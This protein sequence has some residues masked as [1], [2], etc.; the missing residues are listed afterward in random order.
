MLIRNRLSIKDMKVWKLIP[1]I[2]KQNCKMFAKLI[3]I[4]TL[5]V[6]GV[7]ALNATKMATNAAAEQT[8]CMLYNNF[9]YFNLG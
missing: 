7:S 2:N 8:Q 9:A 3:A 4:S 5:V 6:A 1:I